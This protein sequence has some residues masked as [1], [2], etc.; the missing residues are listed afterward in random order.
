M[1]MH[2]LTSKRFL[3]HKILHRYFKLNQT[4]AQIAEDLDTEHGF[5]DRVCEYAFFMKNL[6]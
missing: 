1:S 2:K 6:K 3:V 5:V 4:P